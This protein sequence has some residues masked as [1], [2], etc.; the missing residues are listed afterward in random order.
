MHIQQLRVKFATYVC[1]TDAPTIE[2]EPN[3]IIKH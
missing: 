3:A 1:D 2:T